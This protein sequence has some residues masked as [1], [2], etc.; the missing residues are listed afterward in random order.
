MRGSLYFNMS[1]TH[2]R[3]FPC[4]LYGSFLSSKET[5]TQKGKKRFY[6]ALKSVHFYS[7]VNAVFWQPADG[8]VFN[9]VK[10]NCR[11]SKA[12]KRMSARG[13]YCLV[14]C[15]W[16]FAEGFWT[17]HCQSLKQCLFP[18]VADLHKSIMQRKFAL[19]WM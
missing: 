5:P 6:C 4:L 18:S 16:F 2:Q 8:N 9:A 14:F 10:V 19:E 11:Y 17:S 15:E 3:C 12:W 1:H 13:N 7:K